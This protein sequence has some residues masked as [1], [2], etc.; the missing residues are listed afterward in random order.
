MK[1]NIFKLLFITGTVVAALS[2]CKKPD[3]NQW[4][5]DNTTVI[6]YNPVIASFTTVPSGTTTAA[7]GSTVKLDLRYWSDGPIDKVNLNATVGT[8]GTKQT[9]STTP[10]QKAYS[11]V[12]RTD[13]LIMQYQVPAGTASGT[14]IVVE[15]QVVNK[16]ALTV[17]STIS[18]KVQ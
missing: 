6:G 7:A 15:A 2:S 8:G 18:L 4:L 12:S 14:A 13:S 17:S 3:P 5:K 11:A 9:I 10:Y 16:N 1:F